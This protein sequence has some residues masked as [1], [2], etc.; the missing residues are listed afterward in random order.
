MVEPRTPSISLESPS[1][2][3]HSRTDSVLSL[4]KKELVKTIKTEGIGHASMSMTTPTLDSNP[5]VE[6]LSMGY[7]GNNEGSM[8]T[9]GGVV[10][11]P[12]TF[13]LTDDLNGGRS[14]ITVS[15]NSRESPLMVCGQ[16]YRIM[17]IHSIHTCI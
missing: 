11:H 4:S 1:E 12:E 13:G 6:V 8:E 9:S 17:L 2:L 7:A 15:S 10:L 3:L 5:M 14:L 16:R